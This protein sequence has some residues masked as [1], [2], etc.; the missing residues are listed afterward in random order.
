MLEFCYQRAQLEAPAAMLDVEH[1]RK[2]YPTRAEPLV[3]LRDISFSLGPGQNLAIL[4]PSGSGKSTLLHIIGTLEPPTAGRVCIGDTNPFELPEADLAKFRNE[5]IGFI[6]QEHYLLPQLSILENVLVPALATHRSTRRFRQRAC[7][8]LE[9]VGLKDRLRHRPAELSGGERQRA[10]V[11]RALLLQPKVVLADEPTGSL[12]RTNAASV[13]QLL[14]D[15]QKQENNIL[16]VVTHSIELA[17]R[18]SQRK[19]LDD[20]Y[21]RNGT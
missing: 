10:A 17:A 16:I 12:D 4:G 19:T 20:G 2:E 3:V 15:L 18:L 21:L 8:L 13:G 5:N 14:L 1:I 6:F 11:A 9:R 7:E